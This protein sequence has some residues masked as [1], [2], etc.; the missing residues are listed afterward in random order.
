MVHVDARFL[1]SDNLVARLQA[2]ATGRVVGHSGIALQVEGVAHSHPWD[3]STFLGT[4]ARSRSVRAVGG[5]RSTV[6]HGTWTAWRT[7]TAEVA[8]AVVCTAP[9]EVLSRCA[10]S[11]RGRRNDA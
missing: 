10:L 7:A 6:D 4:S 1:P 3:S 11:E 5:T 9:S 8:G 2:H